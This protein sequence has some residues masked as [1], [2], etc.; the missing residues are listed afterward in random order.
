MATNWICNYA[1]VQ[2]TLPGIENL[3]YKFWIIWVRCITHLT[4]DQNQT[5]TKFTFSVLIQTEQAC[6]CFSFI[7]ITYLFYP[8]TANRTLEDI[9]RFFETNPPIIICRNEL[10]T[11]LARPQVYV[12]QDA[13]IRRKVEKGDG[14][15]ERMVQEKDGAVNI[16]RV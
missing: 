10:A 9:D 4:S 11:R 12:E 13:E 8:E 6:I 1:V 5:P 16:E 3:G 2:A 14:S 7:P 15:D